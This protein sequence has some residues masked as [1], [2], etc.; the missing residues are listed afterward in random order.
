MEDDSYGRLV[1]RSSLHLSV[2]SFTT[3]SLLMF[4]VATLPAAELPLV[5]N[6]KAEAAIVLGSDAGPL[7]RKAAELLRSRVEQRTGARLAVV[8]GAE[9]AKQLSAETNRIILATPDS[10]LLAALASRPRTTPSAAELG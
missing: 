10:R 5:E 8:P 6:G 1:H 4:L 9:A 2:W 7:V 3:A